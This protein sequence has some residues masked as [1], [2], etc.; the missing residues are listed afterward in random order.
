MIALDIFLFAEIL[1][2]TRV[3]EDFFQILKI[4]HKNAENFYKTNKKEVNQPAGN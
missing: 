4:C 1:Y 2:W 3:L